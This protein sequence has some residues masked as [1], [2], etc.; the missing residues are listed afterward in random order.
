M[1]A[2]KD[3]VM[4]AL[5]K[6][7]QPMAWRLAERFASLYR[8][9]FG[10]LRDEAESILGLN[11]AQWFEQNAS[12]FKDNVGTKPSTWIYR[13]LYWDLTTYCTRK[14]SPARPFSTLEKQESPLDHP[15][16][17]PWIERMLQELG[18]DAR[19]VVETILHAPAEIAEDVSTSSRGRARKAVR[20][21][22]QVSGWTRQRIE[23]AWTE[24]D[25]CL[26]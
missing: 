16:R 13:G 26:A 14:Q 4:E 7:H 20:Q 9:P 11:I 10:E 21:Y 24:V 12:A 6:Q 18:E 1:E 3:R 17:R 19:I 5:F 22:L 2:M 8:R 15:C 25:A 23:A